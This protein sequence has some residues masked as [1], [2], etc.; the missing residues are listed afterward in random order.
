[1]R[2]ST[3][4][5]NRQASWSV[6]FTAALALAITFTLS[7]SSGGGSSEDPQ[8]SSSGG[9]GGSGNSSSSGLNNSSS[10]GGGGY[11]Q[12][13]C[14]NA[15]TD[16]NNNTVTCGGKTYKTVKIGN[17]TWMAENLNYAIEG[18]GR[19]CY[20][21]SEANC[22][23]YGSLYNW[24]TAVNLPPSCNT[25]AC[26]S[27]IQENHRG[28]CPEGWHIPS[29]VDWKTLTGY[30]RSD[31]GVAGIGVAKFLKSTEGWDSHATYGNGTDA[32][33]FKALSGGYYGSNNK[34]SNIGK[35]GTWWNSKEPSSPVTMANRSH[36]GYNN[37]SVV[38]GN[39]FKS[40]FYNV[41]CVS[42]DSQTSG[43]FDDF[44]ENSQVY[45]LDGNPYTGSG[46]INMNIT[47][48]QD[49]GGSVTN[50]VVN[51]QLPS[52]IPAQY[53]EDIT[54]DNCT[55]STNDAKTVTA[56]FD[57]FSNDGK[58]SSFFM[59][60]FYYGDGETHLEAFIAFVYVTKDVSTDCVYSD[61]N[62]LY[63][64][65]YKLKR[66]WNKVYVME[67]VSE[68]D[69]TYFENTSTDNILGDINWRIE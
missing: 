60:Y 34:Y 61:G 45:Y 57:L 62:W 1:M 22:N 3:F 32:Y 52:T 39:A 69:G 29:D 21:N 64:R 68:S 7:C 40:N 4:S 43:G 9:G 27:Q 6:L 28:I 17:Q 50:G 30:V 26:K 25:N 63:N 24:A 47:G 58:Q 37:G 11:T 5:C 8:S 66:G 53:L 56:D 13:N 12:G 10:S 15:V 36:I 59:P 41:R 16:K 35:D 19:K 42:D 18:D 51:L 20:D 54:S 55:Y 14:P 48:Y 33:G 46:T 31:K 44:D 2:K 65:N 38:I 67:Y 23:K 49:N